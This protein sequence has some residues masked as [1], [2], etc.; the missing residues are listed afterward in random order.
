MRGYR[1]A[2][3]TVFAINAFEKEFKLNLK[4]NKVR[5]NYDWNSQVRIPLGLYSYE[6]RSHLEVVQVDRAPP[7]SRSRSTTARHCPT[8]FP[9]HSL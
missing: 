3:H 9:Y 1:I 2:R 6:A 5:I 8:C 4:L 7:S